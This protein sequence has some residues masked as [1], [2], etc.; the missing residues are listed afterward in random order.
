MPRTTMLLRGVVAGVVAA[1][2]FA[3]AALATNTHTVLGVYH[4][5]GDGA[6][7][8]YYVHNFVDDGTTTYKYT[9][10][11]SHYDD[12][13]YGNDYGYVP[14]VHNS[15]DPTPY[16]ECNF[17]ANTYA[18]GKIDGHNHNHHYWC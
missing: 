13:F 15:V 18:E 8:N 2:T 14:H 16:N 6:N 10:V 5:L 11:S 1:L 9:S 7:N 4:G 17:Y 12:N 3:T